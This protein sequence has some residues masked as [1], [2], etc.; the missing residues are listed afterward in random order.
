MQS[1][2]ISKHIIIRTNKSHDRLGH[3]I[4][5]SLLSLLTSESQ[6]NRTI[7]NDFFFDQNSKT[8]SIVTPCFSPNKTKKKQNQKQKKH[9]HLNYLILFCCNFFCISTISLLSVEYMHVFL[10]KRRN[11]C[12][13]HKKRQFFPAFVLIL[14]RFISK[15]RANL[16]SAYI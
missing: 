7:E 12:I 3:L 9:T 16:N 11:F 8:R 6:K 14:N 2:R 5:S 4:Y 10:L 1:K 15:L 13:P